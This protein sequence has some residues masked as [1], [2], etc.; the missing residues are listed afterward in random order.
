MSFIEKI[1]LDMYSAMKSA[2]KEKADTLRNLLAK[3]KDRQIEKRADLSEKDGL[4]VIKSQVKQRK[5]SSEIFKK[6]DRLELAEKE[7]NEMAILESY[8]PQMMSDD[9]IRSLVSSIIEDTGADSISD[10][11]KV[12]PVILARGGGRVDGKTANAIVRE[13]LE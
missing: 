13:L 1:K 5:E 4:A 11:G 8:L 2:E 3:L 9:E 12:M 7:K 6:A 10:I